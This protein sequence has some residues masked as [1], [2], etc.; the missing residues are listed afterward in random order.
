MEGESLNAHENNVID[1][2]TTGVAPGRA[3]KDEGD[4]A[5][6]VS[7]DEFLEA[8]ARSVTAENFSALKSNVPWWRN[9][10]IQRF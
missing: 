10:T 6:A 1:S 2:F 3:A 9:R 5:F 8:M 7:A 4:V